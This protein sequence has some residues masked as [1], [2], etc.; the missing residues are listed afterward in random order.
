MGEEAKKQTWPLFK[1]LSGDDA[2]CLSSLRIPATAEQGEFDA[3]VMY[4]TKILI[5]SLNEA[6]IT[7]QIG[8]ASGAKGISKLEEYLKKKKVPD[9][10]KHI[11]FLRDLQSLRSTGAAHRKGENYDKIA[12]KLGL[13]RED[14]RAVFARFLTKA[15]E[16]LDAVGKI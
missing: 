1:P 14:R 2:H 6:E 5:D 4:L 10:E 7:K 15:I 3:Q 11:Q 13:G 9:F 8:S 12:R 16:L